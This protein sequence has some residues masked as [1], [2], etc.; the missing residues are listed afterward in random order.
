M[1]L[2]DSQMQMDSQ[3]ALEDQAEEESQGED[4]SNTVMRTTKPNDQDNDEVLTP[5]KIR[6]ED[7]RK[8]LAQDLLKKNT[9][10]KSQTKG[11]KESHSTPRSRFRKKERGLG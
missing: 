6:E 11:S 3:G 9:E 1:A 2:A 10:K 7:K 8:I 5:V 4:H